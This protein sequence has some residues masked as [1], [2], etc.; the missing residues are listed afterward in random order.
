MSATDQCQAG[1]HH[2]WEGDVTKNTIPQIG[3]TP[4]NAT[5]LLSELVAAIRGASNPA[6]IG[7]VPAVRRAFYA[8]TGEYPEPQ[9]VRAILAP[10]N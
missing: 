6:H 3:T 1:L 5:V 2:R 9:T 10:E 7:E 4:G 8:M